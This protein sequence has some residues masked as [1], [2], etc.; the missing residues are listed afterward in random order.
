MKPEMTPSERG[1]LFHRDAFLAGIKERGQRLFEDGYRA[2]AT[3]EPGVFVVTLPWRDGERHYFV[4][5]LQQT[6]ACPFH[7]PQREGRPLTDDGAIIPCKHLQ[8]LETLVKK[9]VRELKEAG[10]L[11]YF[12]LRASWIGVVAHRRGSL[13]RPQATRNQEAVHTPSHREGMP[14][15][16]KET[17][18]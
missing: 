6:C 16:R 14:S 2:H 3:G 15:G 10:D 1:Y 7:R 9:T 8:G 13:L 11:S 5:A 12:K 18:S 17:A 4:N